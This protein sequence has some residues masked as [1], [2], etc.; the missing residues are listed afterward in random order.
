MLKYAYDV[1][2]CMSPDQGRRYL[3]FLSGFGVVG[4]QRGRAGAK[5]PSKIGYNDI[6]V[7]GKFGPKSLLER[8]WPRQ[9]QRMF[10]P[11]ANVCPYVV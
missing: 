5:K 11:A 10:S 7:L 6:R 8:V 2:A 9:D 1:A 3:D 4:Y